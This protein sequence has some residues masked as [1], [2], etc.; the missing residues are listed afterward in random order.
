MV[1]GVWLPTPV[2]ST[3]VMIYSR[4]QAL[5]CK[6]LY[7]N[8]HSLVQEITLVLKSFHFCCV[9]SELLAIAVLLMCPCKFYFLCEF[10]VFFKCLQC[11]DIFKIIIVFTCAIAPM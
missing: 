6:K 8:M 11:S 3:M 10:F 7:V 1:G 9:V 4:L 5:S 2:N